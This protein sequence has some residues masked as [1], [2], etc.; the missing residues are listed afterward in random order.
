M[1]PFGGGQA[2]TGGR[3]S[4][5]R[6]RLTCAEASNTLKEAA[7]RRNRR[8]SARRASFSGLEEAY[9]E[10]DEVYKSY[11]ERESRER[12]RGRDSR[13][14]SCARGFQSRE[15]SVAKDYS[16]LERVPCDN[17]SER[18]TL[19]ESNVYELHK[20]SRPIYS[21]E[22]TGKRIDLSELTEKLSNSNENESMETK[23]CE[24]IQDIDSAV[25]RDNENLTKAHTQEIEHL[26][27]EETKTEETLEVPKN[28]IETSVYQTPTQENDKCQ[29][30][31]QEGTSAS[32][33][34][35]SKAHTQEIE[36]LKCVEIETEKTLEVP[37]NLIEPTVYQ[38]PTQENDKCQD[39]NQEWTEASPIDYSTLERLNIDN[40][41]SVDPGENR[42]NKMSEDA[43]SCNDEVST[44]IPLTVME[45]SAA[46]TTSSNIQ[47]DTT[48]VETS[49]DT[50]INKIVSEYEWVEVS[51]EIITHEIK[52]ENI[53]T[54]NSDDNIP[55]LREVQ[56]DEY[57]PISYENAKLE[58]SI[59]I[60][61]IKLH[62]LSTEKSNCINENCRSDTSEE[63]NFDN[64]SETPEQKVY[65]SI[66][67]RMLM[68][69]KNGNTKQ[70]V[71]VKKEYIKPVAI[72]QIQMNDQI[73]IEKDANDNNCI[74]QSDDLI[75]QED[76]DKKNVTLKVAMD[77]VLR[78]KS[79]GREVSFPREL[80]SQLLNLSS[81]NISQELQ[82]SC[83]NIINRST[84]N[85]DYSSEKEYLVRRLEELL[86]QEKK[87]MNADLKSRKKQLKETKGTQ[88]GDMGFLLTKQQKE[89]EDMRRRHA[90]E[91]DIL[92]EHFLDRGE[93]LSKEI[94]LLE[95]EM[96]NMK[97]PSQVIHSTL[98]SLERSYS[99]TNSNR[100]DLSEI[101]DELK[102]CSCQKLCKPP[103]KIYQC[104]EGD[105]LCEKCKPNVKSCPE[106]GI[107]LE[108][109]I[110]RNKGL[111]NIA[112]KHFTF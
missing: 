73:N 100:T 31:N 14:S 58:E 106:C 82:R 33:I 47:I 93:E 68:E 74:I 103:I 109:R 11:N 79:A 80:T 50:E 39:E 89:L 87:Q 36:H 107:N 20:S 102:C 96:N 25:N 10:L 44:D 71:N 76:I 48:L 15:T 95:N 72:E 112:K 7:Q 45:I 2:V 3:I 35:Y 42:T 104:P 23:V 52:E 91:D 77:R 55:E 61:D 17:T 43:K 110:S 12:S 67:D 81:A 38:T 18:S 85:E 54:D 24:N 13:E 78:E 53:N 34:D 26:K 16:W 86:N 1:L 30:K 111:E 40:E 59:D 90:K 41:I 62:S 94:E 60:D 21:A 29:D 97:S 6:E 49:N 57:E 5:A 101:E 22:K 98:P 9:Q 51:N 37:K 4:R 8:L 70:S 92:E 75:D 28:L 69:S 105:L 88:K 64:K 99:G 63:E 83:S 65:V 56:R 108:G 46:E 27:S 19:K 32:P 66:V 84:K